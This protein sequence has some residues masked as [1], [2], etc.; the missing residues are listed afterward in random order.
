VF[1]GDPGIPDGLAPSFNAVMP[2]VGLIWDPTGAGQW[3]IRSGYGLFYDQF[4]NGAGTASQA[5]V[6]SIPWAQFNQYS[7]AGLN[8]QN[9]YLGRVYPAPN[10]FVRPSTVFTIDTEAKPPYVHDWN[11]SVERSLF[12]TYLVAVRYIAASGHRLPR[13]VEAN[14]A[15]YGPGAT[16]QNADRRRIYANC[17]PDGS[18]CDFSTIAMLTYNTHSMYHAGQVSLSRRY[19]AGMGFNVSY[20]LSSAKD[21]LSSMNLSGAA[22]KPLAGENDLAQNPFDPAAEYGPSLFDARHRFVASVSWEPPVSQTAP[23]GVR[24]IFGGWQING[25]ATINSG[26]PFTVTDSANV[27]LQANS[28]PISGFPA[29]RPNL[30]GDPN[31]GPHTVDAWMGR[32]AFQRLNPLTQAGQFGDAGRNIVRGPGYANLDVSLVRIL[33]LTRSIRLELRAESFNLTNHVNLGL[34]V[35]D[36]NS[37]NFGRIL[38]AGP[39]RLMQF[40]VKLIF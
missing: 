15:V 8:F 32:S 27:A 10:T 37:S 13:N 22:A 9:P 19:A 3:S 38:S 20:W 12:D 21:E 14:P 39:P 33:A 35:A 6:S 17:P 4:Q 25:I 16:A 23:T 31:A 30:I 24:M 40:A 36:L 28:P 2:R 11:L 18:A 1:P 34:P 29:S 26:T 7:G 5:P